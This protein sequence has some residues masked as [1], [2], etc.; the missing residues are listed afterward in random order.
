M[1]K[2][3]L[4]YCR[5]C[6][7]E[8]KNYAKEIYNNG[9]SKE[10]LEE[11]KKEGIVT[12]PAEPEREIEEEDVEEIL[13]INTGKWIYDKGTNPLNDKVVIT[14]W[15][16]CE[17]NECDNPI[18][19]ILK[20]EGKKTTI[21]INWG[22]EVRDVYEGMVSVRTRFGDKKATKSL[23]WHTSIVTFGDIVK[24]AIFGKQA[25]VASPYTFYDGRKSKFIRKLIDTDRFVA[26]VKGIY[27][28]KLTAIFDVRGFKNAVRQFNDILGWIE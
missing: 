10:I 27:K 17:K 15:L 21:C 14:F 23:N 13:V 8:Q 28:T 18:F 19:L 22:V 12:E 2:N 16:E 24:E 3:S 11:I 7:E 4:T 1:R 26:E 20:K 25:W 6:Q 9:F 5:I